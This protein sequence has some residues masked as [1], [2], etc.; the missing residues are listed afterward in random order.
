MGLADDQVSVFILPDKSGHQFI[1]PGGTKGLVSTRTVSNPRPQRDEREEQ[2]MSDRT[3]QEDILETGN[4][5]IPTSRGTAALEQCLKNSSSETTTQPRKTTVDTPPDIEFYRNPLDRVNKEKRRPTIHELAVNRL[6]SVDLGFITEDQLNPNRLDFLRKLGMFRNNSPFRSVDFPNI[7]DLKCSTHSAP[8]DS[9]PGRQVSQA[10]EGFCASSCCTSRRFGTAMKRPHASAKESVLSQVSKKESEVKFGWIEGVFVRCLQ[11]IIGV[12][13]YLR[14]TWVAGQAGILLGWAIILLASFTTTLTAL[15]TSTICTNGEMKGGGLYYLISRTLGAEFGGSIG[16]IFCLANCVGGALYVVGFAETISHLMDGYGI[17]IIDGGVWDVRIISLA[18][19]T[20]LVALICVSATI[21]SKLQQV[22]L[23]P[24]FLSV[25]S[26]V[27]GSFIWTEKKERYG[28]TGYQADTL[29]ANM[30]P[31]FRQ[32][33]SFFSIFSVYFPAAT[34][35][36]AGANISGNLKNPQDA[37]PRG[38]LSAILVS[39]I[40]YMS[41]LTIAGATYVRDADGEIPLNPLSTPDCCYN[42]SCPFGLLNYYQIVMVTS[43]WPPL[44]T[45]GIVAATL[46]SA[47]ASLISAPK[48]FQAICEDKV[49]PAVHFFA[50]GYGRGNDPRRAYLLAFFVTSAV[51]MIGELNY[52]APFISNF[53][54]CSYALL[55]YSCFSA[56]FS[57]SPGF[58]PAFRYYSHWLSLLG[59]VMCVA[60]MVIMSWLTT[61]LTFLFFLTVYA[62]IKHL[63]PDVNWGTSTTAT[64]YMHTLSGVM[65][66]TKDE[67]HVKNYRPQILVLSGVPYERP[68]L[69]RMAYSITRGTS[70][71][72]CGNVLITEDT[73]QLSEQLET[74]RHTDETSQKNLRKQ[75]IKGVCKSVVARTLEDG[76]DMLCQASGLGKLTPNIVLLGFI[77]NSVGDRSSIGLSSRNAYLKII[78]QAF[79]NDMGV[80]ILRSKCTTDVNSQP[81]KKSRMGFSGVSDSSTTPTTVKKTISKRATIDVW[82]LSD[83]G[84]LTLLVPYLLTR[85][86]SHLEGAYLRIFTIAADGVSISSEEERMASLLQKF[87]IQYKHLHVVAAIKE[88]RKEIEERFYKSL[89]PLRGDDDG[90]ITESEVIKMKAKTARHIKTGILLHDYSSEADLIVVTLPVPI[91]EMSGALYTSWLEAIS[92]DLPNILLIRGN[93]HNVLTFYS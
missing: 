18:T 30:W 19:C 82:W 64:T 67:L 10:M 34:G 50:K 86:R 66:L 36:M 37:I 5:R 20:T 91:K 33:H 41:V 58:R 70:L 15:S 1:D 47:L 90:M 8:T 31:D 16:L 27:V 73:T 93:H 84:G 83:D 79:Y 48:I 44:I 59:A 65:K 60:I 49:I 24:L 87:R 28:Y 74:A 7:A 55:N 42:Y 32:G 51:L 17:T 72:V 68:T 9:S 35:I 43:V 14:L 62:F 71:L 2:K 39:T 52:I 38:T 88:P 23:V 85:K 6:C 13:L 22:L 3:E 12:I 89:E 92:T 11:N 45:V 77:E 69:M 21:E 80:G 75:G 76:C 40:I 29:A 54:L 63:K 25:L 57:Q 53:F 4:S 81:D 26:F 61:L 56:S 78:Q 46:C